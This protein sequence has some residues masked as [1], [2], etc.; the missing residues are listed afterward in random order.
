MMKHLTR[1]GAAVAVLSAFVLPTALPTPVQAQG[2]PTR[3]V[4]FVVPLGPGSGVDIG[5]RLFADRLCFN[6]VAQDV[7]TVYESCT[8]R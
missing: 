4:K 7:L 1:I 6:Q 5:S 3:T 2:W 8:A